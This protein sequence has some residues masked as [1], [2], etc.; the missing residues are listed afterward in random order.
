MI[1]KN[2][3]RPYLL[4]AALGLI[5]T[6]SYALTASALKSL[7]PSLVAAGRATLGLA[8]I[9]LVARGR[10]RQKLTGSQW[11]KLLLAGVSF[12]L[13]LILNVAFRYSN[14]PSGS[15]I[16]FVTS[17]AP[18]FLLAAAFKERI[19]PVAGAF[20]TALAVLGMVVV[21]GNWEKP[22]SFSPF[23]K[24]PG[25][26]LALLASAAFL[27]LTLILAG[28]LR[29][30]EGRVRA[31]SILGVSSIFTAVYAG[32]DLAVKGLP[33]AES[34]GFIAL[35]LLG[36]IGTGVV[37]HMLI[38]GAEDMEAHRFS[39]IILM[40]PVFL[41]L[42]LLVDKFAA[43]L[44]IV[45]SQVI[46]GC[47]LV[48]IGFVL[49]VLPVK[50]RGIHEV[51][52][53]RT[54]RQV[55]PVLAILASVGIVSALAGAFAPVR[56]SFIAGYL[57]SGA[58]YRES[59]STLG[60]ESVGF[61]VAAAVSVFLLTTAFRMRNGSVGNIALIV[62]G[63]SA[64]SAALLGLAVGN[65]TFSAWYLWMPAEIQWAIGTEYVDLKEIAISNIPLLFSTMAVIMGGAV[66]L[67]A[68]A[69]GLL[70]RRT[71]GSTRSE[72]LYGR[73]IS[74]EQ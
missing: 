32:A 26:E 51:E 9:A 64:A 46:L 73:E 72:G 16:A 61:Y 47:A 10:L 19:K 6:F 1:T 74:A 43:G 63:L 30:V 12:G 66:A 41:T 39:S 14:A 58:P 25:E 4:I 2:T 22:S 67:L 15:D 13:F 37:L 56:E 60:F 38:M 71:R 42:F 7:P 48:S 62:A 27:A 5:W 57:D 49:A 59:W 53:I 40:T 45:L 52:V 31:F 68:G 24:F 33:Q 36:V 55:W 8:F 20:G 70:A 28:K 23:V 50:S 65:N 29:E 18:V 54:A 17:L 44:P 11:I 34:D 69:N 3:L 35:L 21:L